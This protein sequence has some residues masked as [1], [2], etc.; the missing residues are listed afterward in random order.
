[1]SVEREINDIPDEKIDEVI[2]SFKA[3][4][5]NPVTKVK[6]PNGLWTVKAICQEK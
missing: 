2:A 4:G 1:M 5:C 3:A 6:Q